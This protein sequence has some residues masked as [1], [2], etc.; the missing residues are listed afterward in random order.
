MEE[1]RTVF[2]SH[3]NPEDN[4]FASWL[5]SKLANAGYDVWTDVL[6][7]V[8]GEM[9]SPGIGDV[10]RDK[11]AIVIIA[12]SRASHRKAGVLNEIA[13]ASTVERK[14]G[15]LGFVLPVVLDDLQTSDFPDDLVRRLSVDF[16]R[17]WQDGLSDVLTALEKA[18]IPRSNDRR[19]AAMAAWLAFKAHGSVLRTDKPDILYSNWFKLGPLPSRIRFSRF[20]S[21]LDIEGAFRQFRSPAHSF[22][23]LAISFADAR[24]L[25]SEALGVRLEDAYE[26]DL[27]DFLAGH[28]KEGVAQILSRDAR[29]ILTA[30]LNNAWGRFAQGRGL[31]RREFVSGDSWF[32]PLGLFDKDRGVFADDNGKTRWRQLAGHSE[33]RRVYWHFG[34]S[35]RATIAEACYFTLRSH[36]VFTEDGQTPLEGDRAQRLRKSFC[37]NWWNPRW[38]DMLRA[39]VA[40]VAGEADEVELR[41]GPN[42]TVSMSTTP[43]RFGASVWVD[44]DDSL[45]QGPEAE[46]EDY[47]Y[48]GFEDAHETEDHS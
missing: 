2:I 43:M 6:S 13:I 19:D 44:D 9:I 7:L 45:P 31:V 21:S 36:V 4:D 14:L 26:V 39:F 35:A 33:A 8:G 28:R 11:A 24:T 16:S 47:G 27:D 25:M 37:K 15:K 18:R 20:L 34:A 46:L 38:R 32:V 48:G 22:H 23:R 3:A 17:D 30:L 40:S 1:R 42:A 12:L 29:N 10:I 5:G 41:L